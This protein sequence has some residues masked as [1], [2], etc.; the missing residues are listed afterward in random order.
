MVTHCLSLKD[1]KNAVPSWFEFTLKTRF[2]CIFSSPHTSSAG[3]LQAP[4]FL[5]PSGCWGY[6]TV[7]GRLIQGRCNKRPSSPLWLNNYWCQFTGEL[8]PV[9]PYQV[10]KKAKQIEFL[11]SSEFRKVGMNGEDVNS[12]R[13]WYGHLSLRGGTPRTWEGVMMVTAMTPGGPDSWLLAIPEKTWKG[14]K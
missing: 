1:T 4:L 13:I 9:R 8:Q 11:S 12:R 10:L 7:L 2:S 3:M 6:P 14:S 5:S